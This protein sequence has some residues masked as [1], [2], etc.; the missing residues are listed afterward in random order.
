[1]LNSLGDRELEILK[2]WGQGNTHQDFSQRLHLSHGTVKTTLA[3]F[4]LGVS[5]RTQAA[6]GLFRPHQ[7]SARLLCEALDVA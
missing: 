6:L 1:M 7:H 3:D 4:E 2:F 5:D